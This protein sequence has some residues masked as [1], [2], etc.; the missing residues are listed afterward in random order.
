MSVFNHSKIIQ[1][2]SPNQ[3]EIVKS[4]IKNLDDEF[5]KIFSYVYPGSESI[6]FKNNFFSFLVIWNFFEIISD[7]GVNLNKNKRLVSLSYEISFGPYLIFWVLANSVLFVSLIAS[8]EKLLLA[9]AA[10]LM[11]ILLM[12]LFLQI[13]IMKLNSKIFF[14]VEKA[15]GKIID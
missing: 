2:R 9:I 14:C 13:S 8:N 11:W 1:V 15:G 6:K 7:G 10:P 12:Y 4:I 5:R 3:N